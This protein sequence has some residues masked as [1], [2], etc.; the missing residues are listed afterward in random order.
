MWSYGSAMIPTIV[1]RVFGERP[2]IT[3]LS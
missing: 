3:D 1:N 2:W